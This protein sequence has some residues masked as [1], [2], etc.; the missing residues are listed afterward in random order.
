MPEARGSHQREKPLSPREFLRGRHPTQF[1]DSRRNI[2]PTL[3]RSL[4]EYHLSTITSRNQ[5]SLFAT[6]AL[7]LAQRTICPNLIP[8][9][10][11]T[12]GGDS[13]VDSETFPVAAGLT[14]AWFVG[15][16]EAASERWA[17]AFSAKEDWRAKVG[18]D[19]AK[20]VGTGRGYTKAFFVSNQ[21]IRDKVRGEVEDKL[22]KAHGLGVRILDGTWILDRV[23]EAHHELLA[24][25]ELQMDVPRPTTI[26]KGPLDTK[27]E[28][29]LRDLEER[30][31][32]ATQDSAHGFALVDDCIAAT[33]I[34]RALER[35]RS[36][37]DGLFERARRNA[38]AFGTPHQELV[39]AYNTAWTAFW[40]HEDFKTLAAVYS[41]VEELAKGS[42]NAY[43][44]ELL[45]NLWNI[46]RT[47]ARD[48]GLT[49][50]EANVDARR[51][52]LQ[53][54]LA[55]LS[56]EVDRPSAALQ[57]RSLLLQTRLTTD[58]ADEREAVFEGLQDVIR[59]SERLVGFPFDSLAGLLTELGDV[60]EA[61]PAFQSLFESIVSAMAT[62]EGDIAAGRLLLKRGEQQL[63]GGR[64]YEAIRSLGRSLRALHQHESR[65]E[66][67]EA[68][69]LSAIAY[70][71]VDLLWAARGTLLRAASI[72]TNE[73]W[74]HE[75]V[76]PQQAVCYGRMKWLELQLG[77]LPHLLAWHEL[78]LTIRGILRAQGHLIDQLDDRHIAFDACLGILL[79]RA[80]IWSLKR[81]TTLPEILDRS[82]LCNAAVAL[83]YSLGHE[84]RVSKELAGEPDTDGFLKFF[85]HWRDQPAS[86]D[87][88]DALALCDTRTET[89]HTVILGCEVSVE[90][91]TERWCVEI[92]EAILAALESFMATMIVD[93]GIARE[94]R[95]TMRLRRSDFGEAPLTFKLVNNDGIP[96]IDLTCAPLD[97]RTVSRDDQSALHD[98]LTDLVAHT[99]GRVFIL[100]DTLETLERLVRD[101]QAL[102]RAVA[103]A[104]SHLVLSNVL[105]HDAKVSLDDWTDSTR[106]ATFP[107]KR[108]EEWDAGDRKALLAARPTRAPLKMGKGPPPPEL[109]DVSQV[110]H[111][112][113]KILSVIREALWDEAKWSGVVFEWS[114][115]PAFPPTIA[116]MFREGQP[117]KKIFEGWR[118][119]IGTIDKEN[120]LRLAIIKGISRANPHAYRLV[121]GPN[122]EA[123]SV[124]Q[125]MK[126]FIGVNRVHTME[127]TAGKNLQRFLESFRRT[128]W[129]VL[130]HAVLASG[131]TVPTVIRDNYLLKGDLTV[132][133]AW[134]VGV[135]D[136]D[137]LGVLPGD[138]PII[139]SGVE[140]APVLELL[141]WKRE[142]RT[143]S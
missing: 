57:A 51:S 11:P 12:G 123:A 95:L 26:E 79:L 8:Q 63:R 133:E 82:M 97:F 143:S 116:P 93:G 88:P 23:F 105:G 129:Y 31:A 74:T 127:P 104:A 41:E 66:V 135:N 46:L 28:R 42:R 37:L 101:D 83:W 84:E 54:E 118:K 85:R 120:R 52:L 125:G 21:L 81:L 141:R 92:A 99:C 13:K 98:A 137:L 19:I 107:L 61:S 43:E 49:D 20:L 86:I 69:Y 40:W 10:G 136:M 121:I 65:D 139:P 59:E 29:Q 138:D 90:T 113:I 89:F 38:A 112:A 24:I 140:A 115:D 131:D 114:D 67:V 15:V 80:D 102:S 47:A 119:D 48:G 14:Y 1:S 87:L 78:D 2:A 4:L 36:E 72:A 6:F 44:L 70:E 111:S 110:K 18:Q 124:P 132:R 130:T 50:V 30:I 33:E 39:N 58:S 94:P 73:L 60:F 7:K 35:P 128:G 16:P 122:L 108:T 68:L 17:F 134:E 71:R 55:R 109:P 27:R 76:T 53:A 142:R 45:T 25:D 117:A 32:H 22:S 77:R 75:S 56:S 9:T 64:P 34:A 100:H 91:P 3:N 106:A 5:E 96:H 126:H 103:F 62:R